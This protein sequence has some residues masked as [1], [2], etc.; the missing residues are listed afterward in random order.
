M[1]D[2]WILIEGLSCYNISNI[3]GHCSN[4]K[5]NVVI[6]CQLYILHHIDK[7]QYIMFDKLINSTRDVV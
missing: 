7:T 4:Y 1:S 3:S 5:I 6:L 2:V